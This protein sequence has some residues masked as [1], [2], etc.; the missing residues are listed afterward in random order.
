MSGVLGTAEHAMA[1]ASSLLKDKGDAF[2]ELKSLLSQVNQ[3]PGVSQPLLMSTLSNFIL[4][5]RQDMLGKSPIAEPPKET[6]D[7][8]FDEGQIIW[9]SIG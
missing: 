1:A 2:D 7:F 5:K 9:S 6:F 8:A 4:S 3:K